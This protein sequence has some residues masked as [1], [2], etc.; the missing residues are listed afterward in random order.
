MPDP[1]AV[2]PSPSWSGAVVGTTTSRRVPLEPSIIVM[3][4][5]SPVAAGAFGATGGFASVD[6]SA[7]CGGTA[8][9]FPPD[10]RRS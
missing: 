10:R 5:L 3:V 9:P 1:T 7:D 4:L 8:A 2:T 6:A